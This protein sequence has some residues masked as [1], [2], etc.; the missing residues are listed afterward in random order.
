ML[1]LF[2]CLGFAFLLI[3]GLLRPPLVFLLLVCVLRVFI[4]GVAD[5]GDMQFGIWVTSYHR[6]AVLCSFVHGLL[7][8]LL[9][10]FLGLQRLGFSSLFGCCSSSRFFLLVSICAECILYVRC[11]ARVCYCFIVY[12]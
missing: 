10:V 6:S 5:L 7:M 1:M 3:G 4:A 2:D 12:F 8:L 11:F 9:K